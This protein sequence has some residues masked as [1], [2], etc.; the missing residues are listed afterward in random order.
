LRERAVLINQL[1]AGAHDRPSPIEGGVRARF[2]HSDRLERELRALV[3]LEA[4]CCAF[5]SL[6][7]S[8]GDD[9]VVLDVTGPPEAQS[10]IDA[11]FAPTRT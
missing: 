1:L 3:A 2:V 11:L 8:R 6:T 10:L 9:L 7:V 4:E 5:L